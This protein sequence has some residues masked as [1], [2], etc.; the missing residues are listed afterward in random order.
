M[1]EKSN[2]GQATTGRR[3]KKSREAPKTEKAKPTKPGHK[4]V[5]AAEPTPLWVWHWQLEAGLSDDAMA[6]AAGVSDHTWGAIRSRGY[7]PVTK[8]GWKKALTAFIKGDAD[9]HISA[10]RFLAEHGLAG[11]SSLFTPAPAAPDRLAAKRAV[12]ALKKKGG[13]L[14]RKS[15]APNGETIIN[16]RV[17]PMFDKT[18]KHFHL[19]GDPFVEDITSE[20]D[21]YTTPKWDAILDNLKQVARQGG[22]RA[23]IGESGSGKS[24]IRELFQSRLADEG[25]VKVVA[26]M[27]LNQEKI[28]TTSLLYSIIEGL[29][30]EAHFTNEEIMVRKAKKLLIQRLDSHKRTLLVIE[31]AQ[32]LNKKTLYFLKGMYE[33]K[34]DFKPLLGIILFA[35]PELDAILNEEGNYDLRQTIRRIE[36][37]RMPALNGE[38]PDFLKFKF[39]RVGGEIE[40]VISKE[41]IKSI[42]DILTSYE[43]TGLK[44]IRV[45]R[46]YPLVAQNIIAKAM[47]WAAQNGERVVTPDAIEGAM[48]PARY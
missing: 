16:W 36:I 11:I 4:R 8:S 14:S 34:H 9:L 47:N 26:P 2:R 12:D 27:A 1:A 43:S 29:G 18:V 25:V 31:D 22:F 20:S 42:S 41:A 38:L 19:T 7:E 33:L 3:T 6:K 45:S 5:A 17:E 44:K 39:A 23:L 21:I 15:E 35:Q 37:L 10:K 32:R 48:R 46:C 13:R 24:V 30:G 28:T 40:K